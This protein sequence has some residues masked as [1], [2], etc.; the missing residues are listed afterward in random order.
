[1]LRTD[2]DSWI[3]RDYIEP[4]YYEATLQVTLTLAA[5][6]KLGLEGQVTDVLALA[7]RT[8]EFWKTHPAFKGNEASARL[9][10]RFV[11]TRG[12]EA[13]A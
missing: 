13:I 11:M 2:Y 4:G 9:S 12:G 6:Q 8:L 10:V 5:A 1:V 7:T 3:E